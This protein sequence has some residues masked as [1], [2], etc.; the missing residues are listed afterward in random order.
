VLTDSTSEYATRAEAARIIAPA[1]TAAQGELAL[2]AS[3]N[4]S[5]TAARKP[6]FVESR[7][8]AAASA[9]DPALKLSLL[10]EALAIAPDDARV[11]VAAVRAALSAG[12]DRL[13]LAMY[14]ASAGRPVLAYEPDQQFPEEQPFEA[15]VRR[16]V[17]DT[18]LLESLS[19]AAERTGDLAAAVGYLQQVQPQPRQRIAALQAEQKRRDENLKRQ[20][21]VSGKSEQTQIVRARLL[22]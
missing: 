5:P 14:Q 16:I 15:P 13:A 12:N 2:L 18:P 22:P 6:F 20:P 9:S 19:A 3:G 7:L 8:D 10:R 17:P 4:K 21:I 11:R 1:Q